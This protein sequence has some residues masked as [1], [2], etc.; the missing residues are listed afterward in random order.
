MGCPFILFYSFQLTVGT[1]YHIPAGLL[2]VSFSAGQ[3]SAIL[4]VSTINDVTVEGSEYFKVLIS[5]IDNPDVVEIGSPNT[6]FITIED[7]SPGNIQH[8]YIA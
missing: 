8:C 4:I 6:S 2:N 1:D 5:S 3:A 7:N